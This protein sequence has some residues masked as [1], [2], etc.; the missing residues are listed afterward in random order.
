[1][2]KVLLIRGESRGYKQCQGKDSPCGGKG[3]SRGSQRDVVYLGWPIAPMDQSKW[4]ARS[5]LRVSWFDVEQWQKLLAGTCQYLVWKS[6][7]KVGQVLID[8]IY[9]PL[10]IQDIAAFSRSSG[11]RINCSVNFFST[12]ESLSGSQVTLDAN[13]SISNKILDWCKCLHRT[14]NF[15]DHY[16][17]RIVEGFWPSVEI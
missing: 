10:S 8:E 16:Q 14:R 5:R 3:Q 12:L 6:E 13:S 11:F 2:V 17:E 9:L 1:M 4:T 7:G 15:Q